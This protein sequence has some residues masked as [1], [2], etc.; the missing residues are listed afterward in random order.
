MTVSEVQT[1]P[2]EFEKPPPRLGAFMRRNPVALK[3][4]RGRMRGPRA[5]V[6]L[7]IYVALMSGFT[8]LLYLIY[9]WEA[10]SN[11]TTTGG[12]I[13]KLIFGGVVTIELFLVCF[14]APA[15]TSGAISGER[16]R[17]TFHILRTT[18]LPARRIVI[19]KLISALAYVILLLFVAVPLQSIAFLLGGVT[20]AEVLLSIELLVVTAIAFGVIGIFFSANMN[21][22]L[23]ASVLTYVLVLLITL[24]VPIGAMVFL[25]FI[26]VMLISGPTPGLEGLLLYGFG[27]LACTNPISTAILTEVMLLT[28]NNVLFGVMTVGSG[29]SVPI[30]SPWIVYTI[31]YGIVSI[32]LLRLTVRRVRRIEV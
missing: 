18:L 14:I 3:E 28:Q 8:L 11:P 29:T 32:V 2:S 30:V 17:R 12:T 10:T 25:S 13:G 24:A 22:T 7:S 20:I 9:S 16:E 1:T 4:L 19:G 27:L 31:L 5:F 26:T 6:I 23:G 15:F 21:R